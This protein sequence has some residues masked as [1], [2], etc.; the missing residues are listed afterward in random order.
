[1]N[2]AKI[3]TI[4][5]T[6]VLLAVGPWLYCQT[7][8]LPVNHSPAAPPAKVVAKETASSSSVAREQK[9]IQGGQSGSMK[10]SADYRKSKLS[11]SQTKVSYNDELK[12]TPCEREILPG[13]TVSGQGLNIKLAGNDSAIHIGNNQVIWQKNY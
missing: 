10:L 11:S 2:K 7:E 4:G 9:S 1:M 5:V 8:R 12:N 13:V 3:W 6:M